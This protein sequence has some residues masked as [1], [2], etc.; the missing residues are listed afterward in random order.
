MVPI[1]DA[2]EVAALTA[3]ATG[4]VAA[5]AALVNLVL[6][7]HRER[8]GLSVSA[9]GWATGPEGSEQYIEVIA[10]NVSQ[11]PISVVSMG[12]ELSTGAR[13]WRKTDGTAS[14]ELPEKLQDG[15]VL[16]MLWLR[17]ELGKDFY[18]GNATITGCFA[19]DGRNNEVFR[20]GGPA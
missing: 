8:P 2:T 14:R 3:A 6:T 9:Q 18:E 15:E 17:N 12:L 4:A 1:A 13:R 20:A 5:V 19:I 11:R 10:A 16:R 7:V